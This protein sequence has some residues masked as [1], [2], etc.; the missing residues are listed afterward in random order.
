MP[1][2]KRLLKIA[3]GAPV[4]NVLL[5]DTLHHGLGEARTQV[6]LGQH[7]YSQPQTSK[8]L[9]VNLAVDS[10]GTLDNSNQTL[11]ENNNIF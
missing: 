11:V 5:R 8:T 6:L 2:V 1:Q 10:N 7:V 3:D 4:G 9:P